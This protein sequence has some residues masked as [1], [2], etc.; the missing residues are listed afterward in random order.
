MTA[1]PAYP[2]RVDHLPRFLERR[3]PFRRGFTQDDLAALPDDPFWDY[4]LHD[5]TLVVSSPDRG[6]TRDDWVWF[7][8]VD[9]TDDPCWTFELIEGELLVTRGAPGER[10]QDCAFSLSILLRQACPPELKTMIAPFDVS[11]TPD[12]CVQPDVLVARRPIGGD[13]LARPP[14][15][16]VEVLSP[17]SIWRDTIRKRA[18]YEKLGFEHYWIVDPTGPSIRSFQL[19]AGSYQE[20]TAAGPGELFAVHR[21]VVLQFD[22]ACLIDD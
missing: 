12:V 13:Y 11:P 2:A 14:V 17:S 10:H 21:P 15:L 16:A 9:D 4:A 5:G 7:P 1:Q 18:A 19:V 6:L 8:D 20:S 3:L 22:P